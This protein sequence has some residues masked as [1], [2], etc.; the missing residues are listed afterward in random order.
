MKI[1]VTGGGGF[2]GTHIIKKLQEKGFTPVSFSRHRYKHLDDLG[3]ESIVG[4]VANRSDTDRAMDGIDAVIHTSAMVGIS[5]IKKPFF[6]TNVIG[7]RNLLVSAKKHG[8]RRFVYCSSPSVV[9]D[10]RDHEGIDE[11]Y[12]YPEKYLSCY[13][14]TKAIA[15]REVLG[16]N[17]PDNFRTCALRPHLIWGPGDNNLLPR[18]AE[19]AKAGK[20]LIVGDGKNVIDTVYVENAADA[21]ILALLAL[22]EKGRADGKAYFITQDEPV[23]CWN[24]FINTLLAKLD[25]PKV[26]KK[27]S[28]RKAYVVG[29]G[30]EI[31]YKL[32]RI[33]KEP[34]MSRFLALELALSHWFDIS[35]AKR[36]L[37]YRPAVSTEE[38]F[39]RVSK[40][41]QDSY[42]NS[43]K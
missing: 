9:F 23:D 31:I 26:T 7:T 37:G 36:D 39:E 4:D 18:L 32:L 12:P 43:G 8:A 38:G 22:A 35:A 42:A 25:L 30:C 27:I 16:A 21:H 5:C 33:K 20:L 14:M 10:G 15:E 34:P 6:E 24:G 11:S 40:W 17:D 13:P 41:W 29:A 1:L 28:L 2:L 19:R 3:V